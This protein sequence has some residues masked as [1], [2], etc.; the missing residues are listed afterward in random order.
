MVSSIWD[1]TLYKAW[2]SIVYSL[3]PNI[4]VLES[5]LD[6]FCKVRNLK[7]CEMIV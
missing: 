1:E 4:N 5:H 6:N 2:S 3:I 7:C